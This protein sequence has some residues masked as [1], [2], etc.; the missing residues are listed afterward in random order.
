MLNKKKNLKTLNQQKI[1]SEETKHR[2]IL[3][4][5]KNFSKDRNAGEEA[6]EI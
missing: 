6:L 5:T 2:K 1:I 4:N 3:L